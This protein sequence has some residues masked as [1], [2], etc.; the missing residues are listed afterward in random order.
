MIKRKAEFFSFPL[1]EDDNKGVKR[2]RTTKWPALDEA[3]DICFE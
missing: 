2:F 1:V 3:I